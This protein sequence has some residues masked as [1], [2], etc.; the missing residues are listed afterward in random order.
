MS[1]TEHVRDAHTALRRSLE[2]EPPADIYYVGVAQVNATLAL[3]DVLSTLV[4]QG[5]TV[6]AKDLHKLF[7][8]DR[9]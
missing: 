5:R 6:P 2:A 9:T 7:E 8:E 4:A 3:V 1:A